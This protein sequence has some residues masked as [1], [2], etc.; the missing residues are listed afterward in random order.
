MNGPWERFQGDAAASD[1]PESDGP[2]SNYQ[3]GP[4]SQFEEKVRPFDA[5]KIR[6]EPV[7]QPSMFS[8][9]LPSGVPASE[10]PDWAM[11][12]YLTEHPAAPIG[13]PLAAIQ[14]GVV[15]P[16]AKVIADQVLITPPKEGEPIIPLTEESLLKASTLGGTK[17][18]A[19]DLIKNPPEKGVGRAVLSAAEGMTTPGNALALPFAF[20]KPIQAAFLASMASAVPEQVKKYVEA[21]T[22][23]EKRDAA[24]EIAL[25]VGMGELMRRGLM[26]KTTAETLAPRTTAELSK[27]TTKGRKCHPSHKPRA[28]CR[29]TR[30]TG[31]KRANADTSPDDRRQA[32]H[33]RRKPQGYFQFALR[34]TEG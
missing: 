30:S 15:E 11:T 23:A 19:E 2:W 7:N 31:R 20:T 4:W 29:S 16:I 9:G 12:Q 25:T 18:L 34:R 28:R 33:W 21:K 6:A 17:E 13:E 1:S 10:N 24:T 14:Q 32:G 3:S 27:N 26:H 22:P 5:S 8:S